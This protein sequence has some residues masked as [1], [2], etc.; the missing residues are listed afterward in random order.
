M[1]FQ[2]TSTIETGLSDHHKLVLSFLKSTFKRLPPKELSYRCYKNFNE[3]NYLNDL[4]N[5][6]INTI[7][8]TE[9]P[10]SSLTKEVRKLIDKNAPLKTKKV[11][12]NHAPFM[13][14]ELSKAIKN[15]SRLKN[16][17]NNFKSRENFVAYKNSKKFCKKLTEN[18]RRDY[19]KDVTSNGVMT[20]REFW[21]VMKPMLTNKGIYDSGT[22]ILEENGALIKE[23]KKL[24]EIFNDHYK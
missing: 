9:D 22:I 13:N 7:L 23:E 5:L 15:R 1:C 21:R 14:K 8:D 2:H 11:R 20:N 19:F 10:Y 18:S 6:P 24:V 17:W 4:K 12:G 16:K 3:D